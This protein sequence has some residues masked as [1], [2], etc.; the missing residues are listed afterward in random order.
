MFGILL[1]A[2]TRTVSV[3]KSIPTQPIFFIYVVLE[4][5]GPIDI[6]THAET[7][8]SEIFLEAAREAGQQLSP[9]PLENMG[10]YPACFYIY[11]LSNLIFLF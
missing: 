6:S 2:L 5:S 3:H 10:T 9:K 4:S 7:M 8:L 1:Y 11:A